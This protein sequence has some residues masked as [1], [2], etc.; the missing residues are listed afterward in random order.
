MTKI[1]KALFRAAGAKG[2]KASG[3]PKRRGNAEFYRRLQAKAAAA[4]R[5]KKKAP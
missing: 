4:R 1:D 5:A 3:K 2:G